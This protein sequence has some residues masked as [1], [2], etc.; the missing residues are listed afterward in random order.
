MR[1][2]NLVD[3]VAQVNYGVWHAAIVN[4]GLLAANNISTELWYPEADPGPLDQVTCISLRSLSRQGLQEMI[5]TRKLDP[6]QDVIITH[7][8]WKYPTRWG[9]ALRKQGFTWI[10]VPQ[11]MLEPWSMQQKWLKKQLYFHLVEK[12]MVA[13]ATWIRA[14]SIPEKAN[15]ASL[16]DP[17]SIRFIPNGVLMEENIG[18][19][20]SPGPDKTRFLF[21]S[22]LHQKKNV[23]A[24]AAAWLQSGLNNKE[25]YELLIAG[26]DQGELAKLQSLIAQSNNLQYIGSVYGE[27][28]KSLLRQC[29]FYVLPSFSEGLPSALLEAMGHGLIPI[30]TEGCNLPEVFSEQLGIRITIHQQQIVAGLEA[31]A[32]WEAAAI[33]EKA[34][35]CRQFIQDHY[36]LP[37]ITSLQL[38]LLSNQPTF[39]P[40]II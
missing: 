8:A 15:L 32:E 34:A 28:K 1:I 13:T 14:V 11:G 40:A 23:V 36:S 30:I 35:R 21:L 5:T 24:L 19:V 3:S 17:A 4:A 9:A 10:Y 27:Q 12:R 22:R 31:A 6:S 25:G 16:F 2:I 26:P 38:E 39:R 37:A 29:T 20:D 18:A 7:G 33:G